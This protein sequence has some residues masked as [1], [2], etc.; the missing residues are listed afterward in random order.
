MLLLCH[1][2]E[3]ALNSNQQ[4]KN[5]NFER[6]NLQNQRADNFRNQ[7]PNHQFSQNRNGQSHFY[8]KVNQNDNRVSYPN[9]RN[10]NFNRNF[11]QEANRNRGYTYQ[12]KHEQNPTFSS[13][14][15]VSQDERNENT[16]FNAQ[17]YSP[18]KSHLK[19]R[20]QT[21]RM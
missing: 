2:N 21:A 1:S 4:K 13:R 18:E 20:G 6:E 16:A 10:E 14:V 5:V 9:Q 15:R 19:G 7:I 11:Q 17:R 3:V 8:E 12:G